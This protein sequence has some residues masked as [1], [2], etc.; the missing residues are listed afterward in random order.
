VELRDEPRQ[1]DVTT[2]LGAV[3]RNYVSTVQ[4]EMIIKH[5]FTQMTCIRYDSRSEQLHPISF[6]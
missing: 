1:S 2:R 3:Y 6:A 5:V 4:A